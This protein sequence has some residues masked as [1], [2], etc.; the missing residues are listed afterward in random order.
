[1]AEISK[2]TTLQ[3]IIIMIQKKVI[4]QKI[5]IAKLDK[6]EKEYKNVK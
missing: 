2:M 4:E 1:M 6:V 3:D 5:V